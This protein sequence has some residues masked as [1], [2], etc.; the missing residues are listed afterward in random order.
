MRGF[1]CRNRTQ[2]G[3]IRTQTDANLRSRG[4][5]QMGCREMLRRTSTDASVFS[6]V[7]AP[8]VTGRTERTYVRVQ[9]NA[10][11]TAV[12]NDR[13]SLFQYR[14]LNIILT[15]NMMSHVKQNSEDI[16]KCICAIF[17]SFFFGA[18]RVASEGTAAAA[19]RG[20]APHRRPQAAGR[21]SRPPLPPRAGGL[22]GGDEGRNAVAPP[23]RA[24]GAP[25][26]RGA[27][28]R[29]RILLFLARAAARAA[30]RWGCP[31]HTPSSPP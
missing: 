21:A 22:R 17:F 20:A 6:N 9:K 1:E 7:F 18:P 4:S 5:R 16:S 10:E 28:A 8:T 24:P 23:P 13:I 2:R 15:L 11:Q 29:A 27:R 19:P 26:G 12:Q 25:A 14:V 31:A 30:C 3:S